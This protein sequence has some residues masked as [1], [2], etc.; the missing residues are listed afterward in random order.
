MMITSVFKEVGHWSAAM[1]CLEL[2]SPLLFHLIYFIWLFCCCFLC[3]PPRKV[4]HSFS[5]YCFVD[6]Y[7]FSF[8]IHSTFGSLTRRTV[9]KTPKGDGENSW[10]KESEARGRRRNA[11]TIERKRDNW[12]QSCCCCRRRKTGHGMGGGE[13]WVSCFWWCN[14]ANRPGGKLVVN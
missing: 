1:C 9:P 3:F 13:Q 14:E 12:V 4:S 6:F 11:T 5:L 2:E 10:R 8:F 7:F